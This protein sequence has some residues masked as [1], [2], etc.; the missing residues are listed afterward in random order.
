MYKF[1]HVPNFQNINPVSPKTLQ[2]HRHLEPEQ[3][4]IGDIHMPTTLQSTIMRISK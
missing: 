3:E 4:C 2:K 1:Q